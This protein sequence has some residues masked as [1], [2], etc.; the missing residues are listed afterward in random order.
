MTAITAQRSR[1]VYIESSN[2]SVHDEMKDYLI[3]IYPGIEEWGNM[4]NWVCF[5]ST[6]YVTKNIT[7]QINLC[8]YVT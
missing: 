4:E 2:V 1:N 7:D 6:N 8:S 5:K 3:Q